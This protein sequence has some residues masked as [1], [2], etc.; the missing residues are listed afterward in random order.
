MCSAT[1][2]HQCATGCSLS[3]GIGSAATLAALAGSAEAA[4]SVLAGR[5]HAFSTNRHT[6]SVGAESQVIVAGDGDTDLDCWR[7][8]NGR[9]IRRDVDETDYCILAAPDVGTH[10]LVIRNLGDVYN[11]YVVRRQ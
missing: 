8:Q 1:S 4:A 7:Y 11:D 9:L 6:I 5:V 2:G 10:Q 3:K